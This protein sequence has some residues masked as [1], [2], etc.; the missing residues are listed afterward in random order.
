VY[1]IS[2]HFEGLYNPELLA[3]GASTSRQ[4]LAVS[5]QLSAV[6]Y[7]SAVSNQHS[8]ISNQPSAIGFALAFASGF[9][10]SLAAFASV[11]VKL[12]WLIADC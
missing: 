10:F 11:A 9:A 5:Y 4:L 8:A 12:L 7:H 1:Q 3:K 2:P 6:S